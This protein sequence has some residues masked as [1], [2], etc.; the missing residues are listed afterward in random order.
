VTNDLLEDFDGL[1]NWSLETLDHVVLVAG[2][3]PVSAPAQS[4][5]QACALDFSKSITDDNIRS[6]VFIA[7]LWQRGQFITR[8]SACFVPI[9]HLSLRNPGLA[10]NIREEQDQLVIR[11][12]SQS[13]ALLVE[14]SLV[15][16]D[17]I[18]SDN[19]FNVPADRTVKISC[20]MPAGWTLERARKVFKLR[21][22]YE[23]YAHG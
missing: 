18:F 19:Y 10:V 7:E 9:K 11:V 22:V 2:T 12:T 8:Q 14:A 3:T 21:S 23:S 6:L 16:V 1:V 15:G 17:T 4:V 5:S 20:L 13:L